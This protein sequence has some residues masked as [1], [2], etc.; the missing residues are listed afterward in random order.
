MA[1]KQKHD[2]PGC[3]ITFCSVSFKNLP[4]SNDVCPFR[5]LQESSPELRRLGEAA[6]HKG[7]PRPEAEH[8]ARCQ[9]RCQCGRVEVQ[10][11][12]RTVGWRPLSPGYGRGRTCDS[13]EPRAKRKSRRR[14][15]AEGNKEG[16]RRWRT[17]RPPDEGADG[18]RSDLN[19]FLER[20]TILLT[21]RSSGGQLPVIDDDHSAWRRRYSSWPPTQF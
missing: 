14:A 7:S 19:N 3:T 4:D 5:K 13:I 2:A 6:E 8:K 21:V 17:M 18:L 20:Q 15:D 11:I 10:S 12:K 16:E 9:C 1:P